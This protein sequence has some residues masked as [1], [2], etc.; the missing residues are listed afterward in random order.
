MDYVYR[1]LGGAPAGEVDL[2]SPHTLREGRGAKPCRYPQCAAALFQC[3]RQSGPDL[4]GAPQ[5]ANDDLSL[6]Y[7]QGAQGCALG[8]AKA[9]GVTRGD[10][11]DNEVSFVITA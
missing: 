3:C 2:C 8:E 5:P 7:A 10:G 4:I 9:A 11:G 1:S 6:G